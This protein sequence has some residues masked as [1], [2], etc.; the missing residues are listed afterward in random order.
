M[1]IQIKRG[2]LGDRSLTLALVGKTADGSSS[3]DQYM[4]VDSI[5]VV[6]GSDPD[7][8][9]ILDNYLTTTS[10][11]SMYQLHAVHYSEFSDNDGNAFPDSQSV[12]DYI[13]DIKNAVDN[14][15]ANIPRVSAGSTTQ[16][17]I[18]VNTDFTSKVEFDNAINYYWDESDFQAGVNVSSYDNRILYG[19][20]STP[21]L[22]EYTLTV[23]TVAGISS[24]V[25]ALNVV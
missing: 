18:P 10:G 13:Q 6:Y 17:T 9:N 24:V 23:Q 15:Y 16:F 14:Y 4:R 3:T 12:V 25:V 22:Y 7:T 1:T 20:I 8:I 5:S 19:N 11:T 21:A 2:L